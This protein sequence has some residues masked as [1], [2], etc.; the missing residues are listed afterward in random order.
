MGTNKALVTPRTGVKANGEDFT[1]I[2]AVLEQSRRRH[3][4]HLAEERIGH[5]KQG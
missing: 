4:H 5:V 1:P 3:W 2:Q